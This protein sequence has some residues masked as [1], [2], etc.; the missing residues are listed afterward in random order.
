M[1]YRLQTPGKRSRSASRGFTMVELMI[2]IA[3]MTILIGLAIPNLR[4]VLA[5]NQLL[6]QANEFAG[7]LA[8]ARTEAATRGQPAGMCASAD[9]ISCSGAPDDWDQYML[10]FADVDAS[11]AFNAGDTLLKVFHASPDV[12]QETAVAAFMF[13][14]S[15]FSTLA[16]TTDIDLCHRE[17][18][19]EGTENTNCRRVSVRPSGSVVVRTQPR[20]T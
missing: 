9:G 10:V 4:G 3:V 5:R 7:A 14:P 1:E 8:L 16:G 18:S 12:T 15:G 2:V 20:S 13:G 19:S 11:G 6:G 17:L